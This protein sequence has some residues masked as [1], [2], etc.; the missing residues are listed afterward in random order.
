MGRRSWTG[1]GGCVPP[2]DLALRRVAVAE[3]SRD[4]TEDFIRV[5]GLPQEGD[6]LSPVR[7]ELFV[8][9][10]VGGHQDRGDQVVGLARGLNEF[11]AVATG[12]LK[13]RDEQV[14]VFGLEDMQGLVGIRGGVDAIVLGR[15]QVCDVFADSRIV[16]HDQDARR[17]CRL[18]RGAHGKHSVPLDA[19]RWGRSHGQKYLTNLRAIARTPGACF[20]RTTVKVDPLPGS[21]V[22]VMS[23]P[24]LATKFR[25]IA[26]PRP[27]PSPFFFVVKKA[28]KSRLWISGGIPD[29]VSEIETATRDP[30]SWRRILTRPRGVAS[31]AF[32]R[33]FTKT[34]W[35][36]IGSTVQTTERVPVSSRSSTPGFRKASV[37]STAARI[38]SVSSVS[39]G[40]MA[41]GRVNFNSSPV[42]F[43]AIRPWAAIFLRR[44]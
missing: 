7:V 29:P 33:R 17:S 18:V 40:L 1:I 41:P 4:F 6:V 5:E 10:Q 31:Y 14:D 24:W 38:R 15:Q 34:S 22:R 43:A 19:T 37:C 28:S 42:M 23:P 16:V 21:D 11:H 26:R 30:R 2:A 3:P 39:I 12:H 35:I 32:L 13:I 9:V 44:S 8:Y 25:L 27:V 20:G 36:R